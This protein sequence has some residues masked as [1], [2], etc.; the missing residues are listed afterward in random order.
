MWT[1]LNI[2]QKG[3]RE[4]HCPRLIG[5]LEGGGGCGNWQTMLGGLGT[6]FTCMGPRDIFLAIFCFFVYKQFIYWDHPSTGVFLEQNDR[7]HVH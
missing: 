2:L 3:A 1:T 5:L 4:I 6:F 7:H